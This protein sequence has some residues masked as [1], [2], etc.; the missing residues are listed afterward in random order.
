MPAALSAT[1]RRPSSSYSAAR[2][3]RP[4]YSATRCRNV[5]FALRQRCSRTRAGRPAV[6]HTRMDQS[7]SATC[8]RMCSSS[9]AA[10]LAA[11]SKHCGSAGCAAAIAAPDFLPS[12]RR[13]PDA[14]TAATNAPAAPCAAPHQRSSQRR[15]AP[16]HVASQMCH[17]LCKLRVTAGGAPSSPHMQDELRIF[18][19]SPLLLFTSFT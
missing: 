10:P 13:T 17:V 5:A 9:A 8:Q 14:P 12:A 6:L 11:A 15:S 19:V 3:A 16:P 1:R 7:F 18:F 2:L 4:S